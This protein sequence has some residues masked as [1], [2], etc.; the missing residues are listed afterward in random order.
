MPPFKPH[1][2]LLVCR[3][4]RSYVY[5]ILSFEETKGLH[6]VRTRESFVSYLF[7]F[8]SFV[9]FVEVISILYFHSKRRK[10]Y[11]LIGWSFAPPLFFLILWIYKTINISSVE[12]VEFVEVISI[13]YFHSKRQKDYN[14]RGGILLS[15]LSLLIIWMHKAITT[16]HGCSLVCR[17]RRSHFYFIL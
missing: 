9:E 8:S 1:G 15:Y 17:V 12:F 2:C 6:H 7:S 3:V 16:S 14:L 4:C 5:F 13:L 11:I 10:G